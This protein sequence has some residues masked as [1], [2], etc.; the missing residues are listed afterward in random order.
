MRSLLITV[1]M[2]VLLGNATQASAAQEC[3]CVSALDID[4]PMSKLSFGVDAISRP[5]D[6]I[7][8][9]FLPETPEK[10]EQVLWCE[11]ED[12]PRC[13]E[14]Q[15]KLPENMRS[16]S[17]SATPACQL[18]SPREFSPVEQWVPNENRNTGR[19]FQAQI[20]RPPDMTRV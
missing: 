11:N 6:E 4:G 12:D 10:P 14:Q 2:S 17:A 15:G 7:M 19:D 16:T 9:F 3:T 20:E 1:F 13:S 18:D 8:S 5:V